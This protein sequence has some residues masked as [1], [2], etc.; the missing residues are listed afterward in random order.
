VSGRRAV[1]G[2][3]VIIVVALGALW[4][5][6]TWVARHLLLVEGPKAIAEKSGG[7]YQVDVGRVRFHLGRSRVVVDSIHVTTHEAINAARPRPRATLRLVFHQC[8]ISGMHLIPLILGR[9][10]TADSFG[11]ADVSGAAQ[12]P[13]GA[14]D[15]TR[16][17]PTAGGAFFALQQGLRLPSFAPRVAVTQI[18]FPHVELDVRLQRARGG[19]ARIVLEHLQWRM[20]DLVI[21]PADSISVA[22]PLFSRRVEI[23]AANFVAHPDSATAVRVEEFVGSLSDSTFV[24]RGVAFAP[25]LSD[26]AFV[27]SRPYRRS[28]IKAAVGRIAVHGLDVGAMV[29][30]EGFRA[31]RVAID[32]L[33]MDISSDRRRPPNPRRPVRRTPQAW[34]ADLDRSVSIDSVLIR[35]G[36]IVYREQRPRQRRPGV[37][38]FAR[39]EAVAVNVRHFAGRRRASDPMTLHATAYLQNEGRLD[40]H[41]VAP[42]DAPR[43]DMTFRGRLGPMPATRLNAFI[44]HAFPLRLTKGR[45][46]EIPFEATVANGVARGTVTPRYHD[47]TVEVTGHGAKGILNTGG[48]IGDAARGVATFVGNATAIHSDNPDDGETALRTGTINHPF[49]PNETLPAFLW[50]SIRDGLFAV[51]RK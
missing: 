27:R 40:A 21:D 7:V 13:R 16:P 51:V 26:S 30:R 36:E 49:T 41:F 12:V 34:I 18:E 19:E 4:W 1:I 25:T 39:L 29:L 47:L 42:L 38:T 20:S 33:R 23:S 5:R 37:M 32:S 46:V 43:F 24:V 6:A 15:T 10:L 2:L 17:P 9:G 48:V 44:E 3:V 14:P 8:T 35:N 45:I 22:R 11:C 28:L 31:R 50:K